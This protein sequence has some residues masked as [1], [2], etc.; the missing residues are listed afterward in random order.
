M[1]KLIYLF[2]LIILLSGCA[3]IGSASRINSVSLGMSK[4]DVIRVMGEPISTA[5]GEGKEYL[6]YNLDETGKWGVREPYFVCFKD[7]RVI[8]YGRKG[9]FGTSQLPT[10]VIQVSG[11]LKTD[12][13]I[14]INK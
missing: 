6:N 5:A 12:S 10:Q 2:G 13:N 9:D 11:D 8:S 14:K 3:F 4:E 1:K 7:G